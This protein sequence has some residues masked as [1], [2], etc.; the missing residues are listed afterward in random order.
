MGL[1]GTPNVEKMEAKR[2]VNGLIKALSNQKDAGV[3]KA[4][5]GA[6]VRIGPPAI[7]ALISLLNEK[8]KNVREAAARMLAGIGAPAVEP[9]ITALGPGDTY[10]R[11]EASHAL[12]KVGT[13]AVEPLITALNSTDS[14]IR[15]EAAHTLG[16]M[17]TQLKDPALR[18]RVVEALLITRMDY[19]IISDAAAAALGQIGAQL[20]DDS[21][22]ARVI[23]TLIATHGIVH[24]NSSMV[25]A[26]ALDKLGWRA[27]ENEM[28]KEM[29]SW[30]KELSQEIEKLI[31]TLRGSNLTLSINAHAG[32]DDQAKSYPN[33]IAKELIPFL[34]DRS[35]EVR[36]TILAIISEMNG[37]EVNQDLFINA[38]KDNNPLVRG[39]VAALLG[40]KFGNERAVEPLILALQDS[41]SWV[42]ALS[43][44]ALGSLGMRLVDTSLRERIKEALSL[45]LI[46]EALISVPG[47]SDND[48]REFAIEALAKLG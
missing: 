9:L 28:Q 39:G 48:V 19:R 1:F 41:F 20:K 12:S 21:L 44:N 2:D 27:G 35:E 30:S 24:G 25:T 33:Y 17:D 14:Y 36:G 16:R 32:L 22:R 11:N 40:G 15:D 34:G 37:S 46:K 31:A 7:E 45:V 4:A 8:D 29:K 43:A 10:F 42:R 23:N 26:R 6:L 38:L 3:C 18:A 5:E 47:E 13:P